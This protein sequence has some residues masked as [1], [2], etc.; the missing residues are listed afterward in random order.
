MV[1]DSPDRS[2]FFALQY[3]L[4]PLLPN[5]LG[6]L[7]PFRH[8]KSPSFLHSPATSSNRSVLA[9]V[10]GDVNNPICPSRTAL[11][12]VATRRV[13]GPSN[14]NRNR[15]Q[16]FNVKNGAPNDLPPTATCAN[17]SQVPATI[18]TDRD[19]LVAGAQRVFVRLDSERSCSSPIS[20]SFPMIS[21]SATSN[22]SRAALIS[23]CFRCRASRTRSR[24]S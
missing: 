23:S 5:Q 22:L 17:E 11:R 1:P 21:R 14:E 4:T 9:W 6:L 8:R 7:A 3:A 19:G 10:L 2:I 12:H 16:T 18:T 20:G 15:L 24:S 13:P